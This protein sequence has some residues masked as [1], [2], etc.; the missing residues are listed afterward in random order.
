MSVEMMLKELCEETMEILMGLKERGILTEEE[1]EKHL[2][3][4]REFIQMLEKKE[5]LAC[6]IH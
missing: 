6:Y 1:L 4:K 3:E 2:K 5:E